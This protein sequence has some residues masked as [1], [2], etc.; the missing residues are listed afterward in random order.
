MV[1]AGLV[2][3]G[4]LGG[5]VFYLLQGVQR[6]NEKEQELA[7]Q[8]QKLEGINS[9]EFTASAANIKLAQQNAETVAKFQA[10]AQKLLVD[11]PMPELDDAK[12]RALLD[13]TIYELNRGCSDATIV[14]PAKYAFT[15]APQ[16]GKLK[17]APNSI[18]PCYRQL[19]DIKALVGV[20]TDAKIHSIESLRRVRVSTDDP[21]GN[22]D[23]LEDQTLRTNTFSVIAPYEVS[24]KGFSTELA[25]VL[26]GL[27]RTPEF[28]VVKNITVQPDGQR[29]AVDPNANP[30]TNDAPKTVTGGGKKGAAPANVARRVTI[31]DERTLRVT[32]SIESV[33]PLKPAK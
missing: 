9:S 31:L 13:T 29:V 30:M 33:R 14:I 1:L 12:F 8:I 20:L 26:N 23:Y 24:F 6:G 28:F 17:Y 11:A 10:A 5:A 15:F 32:L 19:Q 3:L 21:K 22:S 16:L 18:E 2:A 7:A 25:A 27:A 4:L